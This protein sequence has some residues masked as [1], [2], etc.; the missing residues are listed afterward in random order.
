MSLA[1]LAANLPGTYRLDSVERET[2]FTVTLPTTEDY[3]LVVNTATIVPETPDTIEAF[4]NLGGVS[5]KL[6]IKEE[7][8]AFDAVQEFE[9]I[10][11]EQISFLDLVGSALTLK[12]AQTGKSD[13]INNYTKQP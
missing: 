4:G 6:T 11:T 9:N 8:S 5:L 10:G 3:F 12:Q 13:I 7:G 1:T 2:E